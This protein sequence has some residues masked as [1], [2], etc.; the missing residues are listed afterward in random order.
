[1]IRTQQI[2]FIQSRAT[3]PVVLATATIIAVGIGLP[4]SHAGLAI[5]MVPLPWVYFLWLA[6]MLL[7][8]CGLTQLVKVWYIRRFGSWL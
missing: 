3:V 5:G 8:Y 4:F 7:A 1:M 6:A 2:P